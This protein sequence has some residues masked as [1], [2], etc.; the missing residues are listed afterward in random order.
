MS[1][2]RKRM[3]EDLRLRNY[4]SRTVEIYTRHV[5]SFARHFGRSPDQ[6]GPTDVRAYQ[7]HLVGRKCSWSTF[8]QAVCALRFLYGVTLGRK[9][10]IEQIPFPRQQKTLPVVLSVEEVFRLLDAVRNLKHRTALMTIYG[11]GLRLSE[12]LG[13]QLSDIDGTRMQLRVRLGKGK[14][15]RYVDLSPSLLDALRDYWKSQRPKL[16][17]FPGR[18]ADRPVHPTALQKAIVL[19]RLRAGIRKPVHTHTLRH[20]F[21]THLL[22]AGTN[23][24]RIQLA[25]GHRSLNTT[26]VYLH[27]ASRAAQSRSGIIDLLRRDRGPS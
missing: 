26:A 14:R 25:L 19:A 1:V 20:C 3:V 11:A 15:D 4:S 23:L 16:W 18:P 17:L 21:A 9:E 2:L 13:L 10:M 5:A 8:N 7:S 6:L 12:A 22:E 27:V 24:R